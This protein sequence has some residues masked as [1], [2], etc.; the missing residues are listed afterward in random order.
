MKSAQ[1]IAESE[2]VI[3]IAR[4]PVARGGY[5]VQE[6]AIVQHGQIEPG[7]VPRDQVRRE[8]VQAVE[9]SLERI[10]TEIATTRCCSCDRNS[11]PVSWRRLVNMICA[12]CSSD[13][14]CRP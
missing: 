4:L 14:S 5:A 6:A 1:V 9:E 12:T 2:A 7:A 8:L 11:L 10:T 13:R 3:G